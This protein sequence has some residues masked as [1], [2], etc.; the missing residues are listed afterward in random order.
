MLC[1]AIE[2]ERGCHI[3]IDKQFTILIRFVSHQKVCILFQI[4]KNAILCLFLKNVSPS[5]RVVC[6]TLNNLHSLVVEGNAF[7]FHYRSQA[8]WRLYHHHNQKRNTE[9]CIGN[10]Q[11]MYSTSQLQNFP[12]IGLINGV[13]FSTKNVHFI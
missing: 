9:I 13:F 12:T 1:I 2:T 5:K 3:S 7:Y 11:A 6:F 8:V 10:L 4:L